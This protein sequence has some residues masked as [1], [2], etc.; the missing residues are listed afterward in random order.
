MRGAPP[1]VSSPRTRGPMP[2]DRAESRGLWSW[3]PDSRFAAS[4]TTPTGGQLRARDQ[5]RGPSADDLLARKKLRDL[6]FRRLGRV[7]AVHRV[8]ADRA[9]VDLADG[10]PLGFRRIGGA[11]DL[12]VFADRILALEHLHHHRP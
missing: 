5:S 4:G 6:D 7:G 3:V 8:L 9:R 12:P 11:H 2:T 10:S 1:M